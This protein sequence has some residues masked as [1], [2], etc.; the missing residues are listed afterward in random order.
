MLDGKG[1]V[2]RSVRASDV[3]ELFDLLRAQDL[4]KS[5]IRG[6]LPEHKFQ[7]KFE[8]TGFWEEEEGAIL[9]MKKK[10]I[11]GFI[12]YMR[13]LPFDGL[14]LSICVFKE[15]DRGQGLMSSALSLFSLHLFE[16][17]K[18][19][20]LQIFIPDYNK[21][22]IRVVQKCRFQFEGIAREAAFHRGAYRDLCLYSLLRREVEKIPLHP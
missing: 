1:F 6:I 5:A 12:E 7:Q 21:A 9:I 15:E 10:K 11:A 14:N 20:R 4:L 17:K 8:E 19:Q 13:A 18:I 3:E 16:T 2:L 22:A